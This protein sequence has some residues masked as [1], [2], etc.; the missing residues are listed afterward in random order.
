MKLTLVF[1]ALLAVAIA[2]PSIAAPA[3]EDCAGAATAAAALTTL[4]RAEYL[5]ISELGLER[6]GK[7]GFYKRLTQ[8]C[9]ALAEQEK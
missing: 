1:A 5:K 4:S 7:F 3:S 6:P 8:T 2:A 9:G